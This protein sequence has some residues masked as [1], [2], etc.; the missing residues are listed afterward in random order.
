MDGD[1]PLCPSPVKALVIFTESIRWLGVRWGLGSVREGLRRAGIDAEFLYWRWHDTWRGWLVLPA[2][3][4]PVML[5]AQAHRLADFVAKSRREIPDRPI[6]VMGYSCGAFVA[7]RALELLPPD[8][9]VDAA[10]FL[11]AAFDPDHDMTV[12][13]SRVRGRIVNCSSSLDFLIVGVGT[14][15]FGTAERT[16]RPSAGMVGLRHP[17]ARDPRVVQ[18]HW[19]PGMMAQG[20]FGDHFTV[21]S[22]EFVARHVAPLLM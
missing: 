12:A 3:M 21:A 2:I 11:A 19:R 14:C 8:V 22:P 9:R 4:A 6:Y 7:L 10:V 15:L 1:I 5:E 13:V 16:F 20:Y 17:S 18:V